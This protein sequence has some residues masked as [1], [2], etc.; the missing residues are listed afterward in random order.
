LPAQYTPVT[1][2]ETL[3]FAQ[4]NLQWDEQGRIGAAPRPANSPYLTVDEAA[5]Y[6]RRSRKTLLNHHSLGNVR[7]MP[8]TRPPLFRKEDLDD[9][10]S[11]RRRPRRK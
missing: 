11:A 3:P 7:S 6:C 8:S 10:L 4:G 1:N 2:H 5:T 9:W